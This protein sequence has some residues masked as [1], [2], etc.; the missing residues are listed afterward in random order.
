MEEIEKQRHDV[1]CI[2]PGGTGET[3]I[4]VAMAVSA[5][6]TKQVNRIILA[7]PACGSRRAAGISAGTLQCRKSDPYMRPLYDALY[8]MVGRGQVERFWKQGIIEL[9]R[10]A[11]CGAA[12]S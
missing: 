5:L 10:W 3:Y 4:A 7:R 9:R 11:S 8:D 2:G 12:T 6:L 1:R